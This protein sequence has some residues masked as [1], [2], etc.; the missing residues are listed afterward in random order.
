MKQ[1][2]ILTGMVCIHFLL[3]AQ[4]VTLYEKANFAGESKLLGVGTYKLSEINFDNITTSI[5][6]P[7]GITVLA[8]QYA[9][10]F[11]GFGKWVDF[12][13][14][15][16]D[17]SVFGF[18]ND[19]SYITVANKPGYF[20][21]RNSYLNGQ[22]VAGHWEVRR[23]AGNP[24]NLVVAVGPA[25]PAK[26]PNSNDSQF[27]YTDLWVDATN[28]LATALLNYATGGENEG[29]IFGR[30]DV[31]RWDDVNV[32]KLY[33]QHRSV[34]EKTVVTV[35]KKSYEIL[36]GLVLKDECQVAYVDFPTQHYT[37]DFTFRVDPSPEYE[38]LLA[39]SKYQDWAPPCKECRVL[40]SKVNKLKIDRNGL[41]Q[42]FGQGKPGEEKRLAKVAEY[43][44][45]IKELNI[46]IVDKDCKTCTQRQQYTKFQE[47][48][49]V[50]WETGLGS[51]AHSTNPAVNSNKIGNSFGFFTAGHKR[52]D[53]IW[54]WP[55]PGDSIHAEGVWNWE[56]VHLPAHTEMHPP[57]FI[58]IKRHLP[59]SFN[60]VGESAQINNDPTDKYIGTRIDI[61]A[62][63]DGSVIWNSKGLK[64][65]SQKVDMKR[66]DYVFK[67]KTLFQKPTAAAKLSWK[68]L[69]RR[70]DNFPAGADLVIKEI[71]GDM[72][73]VTIPWKTKAV[74][75]TAVLARTIVVY[76]D[77]LP[78]RGV[79][80]EEKPGLYEI[81]LNKIYIID[82]G[83]LG[84]LPGGATINHGEC[85]FYANI[86]SEWLCLNEF[87]TTF[88][89]L[90]G[91]IVTNR[92]TN[93]L[94]SGLGG[95]SDNTTYNILKK[96]R[97]YVMPKGN[98][99][100]PI[101]KSFR[102]SSSGWEKDWI[103]G[104]MGVVT[105]EYN[106]SNIKEM[107]KTLGEIFSEKG[108]LDGQIEDE[109]MGETI[110]YY[111]NLIGTQ[112][113]EIHSNEDG[114]GP[115]GVYKLSYVIKSHITN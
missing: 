30:G 98:S 60:P 110:N 112:S 35:P 23:A 21:A 91:H 71:A 111:S 3:S 33:P 34:G 101:D 14:N 92:F 22:F 52:Y 105:D 53:V 31:N 55:T 51:D 54:N 48:I 95:A 45:K 16:R 87:V 17:L 69:K 32:D 6:I 13:E 88:T 40:E 94:T 12:L 49:E 59:V 90:Y 7:E 50:E 63:A 108:I 107:K 41:L 37:H 62:N 57:H 19:I 43:D 15:Q 47:N 42:S 97:T 38:Y 102:I 27:G 73:E 26:H 65:F 10:G 66:K 9:D 79:L 81:S 115:N 70:G 25:L 78:S 93:I 58:A 67:F 104:K 100:F 20:W 114:G 85:I 96:I 83:D 1:M 72:I 5:R 4:T 61:F 103:D 39:E 106:R 74:L 109:R 44:K 82:N 11:G 77:D 75:N 2:L 86:G 68:V 56:R 28:F 36:E 76:W 8:Y 29:V 113:F 18:D 46:I 89:L 80:A 84:T 24:V 99:S 64:S